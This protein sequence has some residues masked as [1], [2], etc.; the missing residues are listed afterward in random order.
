MVLG[1]GL[2]IREIL[3]G[4]MLASEPEIGASSCKAWKLHNSN[5]KVHCSRMAKVGS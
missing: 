4:L 3:K 2:Y 5:C 1:I